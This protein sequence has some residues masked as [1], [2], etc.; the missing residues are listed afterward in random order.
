[1]INVEMTLVPPVG[2]PP[3]DVVQSE[4]RPAR[5]PRAAAQEGIVRRALQ[6]AAAKRKQNAA[7]IAYLAREQ[8]AESPE[9]MWEISGGSE[10]LILLHCH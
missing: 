10:S 7:G 9:L 1:M 8:R 3:L 4:A 2:G 5:P 6:A